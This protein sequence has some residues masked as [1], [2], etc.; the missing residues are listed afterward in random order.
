MECIYQN[1]MAHGEV[2]FR[3]NQLAAELT[4]NEL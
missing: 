4:K 1:L 3:Y 2:E